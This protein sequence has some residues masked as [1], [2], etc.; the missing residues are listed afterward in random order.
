MLA[1]FVLRMV[2]S[3]RRSLWFDEAREVDVA[4]QPLSEL[5]GYAADMMQPPLYSLVLHPWLALGSG[6][7]WLRAL[8]ALL[9]CGA[10]LAVALWAAHRHGPR[11]APWAGMCLALLPMS[12]RYGQEIGEYALVECALAW[13][14]LCLDRALVRGTRA[15]WVAFGAAAT[16]ALFSHYG[17]MLVLA[18]VVALAAGGLL[19]ARR[20]SALAHLTAAVAAAA[21]LFAP[22]ALTWLPA[23]RAKVPELAAAH[24]GWTGAG[25]SGPLEEAARVVTLAA[26]TLAYALTG[27]PDATL[28]AAPAF[29]AVVVALALSTWAFVAAPAT[30]S[31]ALWAV[32][33]LASVVAAVRTGDYAYGEPWGRYLVILG[34]LVALPLGGALAELERRRAAVA[35][36]LAVGFSAVWLA[37]LPS[38]AE[39]IGN[40][41]DV[42]GAF[43]VWR[44]LPAPRPVTFVHDGAAL[45]FRYSLRRDATGAACADDPGPCRLVFLGE[46]ERP[47]DPLQ[48]EA[49]LVLAHDHGDELRLLEALADYEV[50]ARTELDGARV[51]RLRRVREPGWIPPPL[52]EPE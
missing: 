48:P 38:R 44:A 43:A 3:G 2:G 7:V 13:T 41:E 34:P 35:R 6:E 5:L 22:L 28:G 4:W 17:A 26:R 50:A 19:R 11:A 25:W 52:P 24:H 31:A 18:P 45:S 36:A 10:V 51:V 40:R 49:L 12:V 23:A 39:W 42:R 27:H 15:A 16:A 32:A 9:S 1:A 29:V 14:C 47:S 30:R 20:L 46:L 8:S 37:A 21:M 33:A